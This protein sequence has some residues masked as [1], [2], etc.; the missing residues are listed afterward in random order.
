LGKIFTFEGGEGMPQY[1]YYCNNAEN[2]FGEGGIL[3][4]RCVPYIPRHS[5]PDNP[6]DYSKKN[7]G[8]PGE[9]CYDFNYGAVTDSI[10]LFRIKNSNYETVTYK[11]FN[12]YKN[13]TTISPM[14]YGG[15]GHGVMLDIERGDNGFYNPLH[16]QYLF[17][18]VKWW[19]QIWNDQRMLLDRNKQNS[20]VIA[21]GGRIL[22]GEEFRYFMYK[23]ILYGGKGFILDGE[24]EYL[25]SLR[26]TDDMNCLNLH[27]GQDFVERKGYN[28]TTAW[29]FLNI[30]DIGGDFL[31]LYD[32]NEQVLQFIEI[33]TISKY[34]NIDKHRYYVGRKSVRREFKKISEFIRKPSVEPELMSFNLV[35]AITKGYQRFYIQDKKIAQDSIMK[36]YLKINNTL[37]RPLDRMTPYYENECFDEQNQSLDSSFY[38]L[39]L[40]T[41]QN[42]SMD[43]C[44][45][46]GVLNKRCGPHILLDSIDVGR[47]DSIQFFSTAELEDSIATNPAKWTKYYWRRLGTREIS[48]FFND[49]TFNYQN[50]YLRITEL[51]NQT[52]DSIGYYNWP[53]WKK[54]YY[55]NRIDK[56]LYPNQPLKVKLLPG[57]GKILKVNVYDYSTPFCDCD[58]VMPSDFLTFHRNSNDSCYTFEFELYPC[59]NINIDSLFLILEDIPECFKKFYYVSFTKDGITYQPFVFDMSS[60]GNIDTIPLPAIMRQNQGKTKLQFKLCPQGLTGPDPNHYCTEADLMNVKARAYFK[61]INC[62]KKLKVGVITSVENFNEEL[63]KFFDTKYNDF[64]IAPNPANN[65]ID[66]SF[67][68]SIQHETNL[69]ILDLNGHILQTTNIKQINAKE[70]ISL[71]V[72]SLSNGS[73]F[74]AIYNQDVLL[75]GKQFVITR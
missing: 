75:K 54:D 38:H 27:H 15:F 16:N 63:Y 60:S 20:R 23:I 74:I 52:G 64:V 32:S 18:T 57:F 17:D 1:T 68:Q 7:F 47:R 2:W 51:G 73:Y 30:E 12:Y 14:D 3:G 21:S 4:W 10:R 39:T 35:S 41:K 28:D 5:T 69:F 71:N 25:P 13:D 56:F 9:T 45:Y 62:E 70:K 58:A 6:A 29:E 72:S 46:V 59:P 19:G 42:Q 65:Q 48:L 33:D 24:S 11:P 43:T 55:D 50:K 8:W 31:N 22:T 34:L 66:L 40:L 37:T 49:T 67:Q 36:K 44:F 61:E 53:F 26:V